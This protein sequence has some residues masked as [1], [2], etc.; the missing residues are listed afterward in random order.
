MG[1]ED[2]AKPKTLHEHL[3]LEKIEHEQL[4]RE[5]VFSKAK[6]L[7]DYL[8]ER[9][10]YKPTGQKIKHLEAFLRFMKKVTHT[11]WNEDVIP[12][13]LPK[14][15]ERGG[16]SMCEL[17]DKYWNDGIQKGL[18]QGAL[19][20]LFELVQDALITVVIAAGKAG[21]SEESFVEEMLQEGYHLPIK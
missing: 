19:R 14:E 8:A 18:R 1:K 6:A 16:I 3:G 13:M 11:N 4:G 2:W 20:Q 15:E 9:G 7:V 5:A 17:L 10:N 21:M 12:Q